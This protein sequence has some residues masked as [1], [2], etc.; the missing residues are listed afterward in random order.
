MLLQNHNGAI[1]LL[2]ALPKAWKDVHVRGL[3]ARGGFEIVDL[4]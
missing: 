1:S 2:P 4:E 3:K